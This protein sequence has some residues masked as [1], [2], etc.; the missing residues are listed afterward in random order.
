METNLVAT[1]SAN[2]NPWHPMTRIAFRFLVLYF[3][4][5]TLRM[6]IWIALG[7]DLPW[8]ASLYRWVASALSGTEIRFVTGDSSDTTYDYGGIATHLALAAIG[9]LLWSIL[10]HKQQAY[11]RLFDAQWMEMRFLLSTALIAYGFNKIYAF[12]MPVPSVFKLSTPLGNLT[13]ME[14]LWSFMGASPSYQSI[15]GWLEFIPGVLLLFRRTQLLAALVAAGVLLNVWLMNMCYGVCVK[16]LSLHLLAIACVII[17]PDASRLF[18]FLVLQQAV[19]PRRLDAPWQSLWLKRF[20]S[21]GRLGWIAIVFGLVF[22]FI[23]YQLGYFSSPSAI[24]EPES[25]PLQGQRFF[26]RIWEVS[27]FHAEGSDTLSREPWHMVKLQGEAGLLLTSLP[28]AG[29]ES[30]FWAL[31]PTPEVEVGKLLPAEGKMSVTAL[32]RAQVQSIFRSTKE[33]ALP[34][35]AGDLQYRIEGSVENPKETQFSGELF[36][37]GKP[38]RIQFTLVKPTLRRNDFPLMNTPFR[39]IQEFADASLQ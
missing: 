7:G 35:P 29:K 28:T 38:V 34:E 36:L 23:P 26:G 32:S 21:W 16:N 5:F 15:T 3:G 10:G 39:W 30:H 14:L 9:T 4:M 18:R 2:A 31:R 19:E 11:P 17:L 1:V 27:G 22:V 12:Q 37:E 13:P 24:V 6:V 33:S 8:T 20:L 25:N